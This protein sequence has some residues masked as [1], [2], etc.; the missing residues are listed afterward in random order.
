MRDSDCAI[1]VKVKLRYL[2]QPVHQ[3][4]RGPRLSHRIAL[5]SIVLLVINIVVAATGYLRELVLARTF[6]AGTEMDAFYF[7]LGLVQ[8][9]P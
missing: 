5:T 2:A 6:G 7:T 1:L 8:A 4:M 3:H 9:T